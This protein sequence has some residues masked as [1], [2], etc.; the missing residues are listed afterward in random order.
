MAAKRNMD[1]IVQRTPRRQ[2]LQ[3]FIVQ[4]IVSFSKLGKDLHG[5]F[6][7]YSRTAGRLGVPR[8]QN[9]K[10][11][12][13]EEDVFRKNAE[14]QTHRNFISLFRLCIRRNDVGLVG[15]C[16][17][18]GITSG[19]RLREQHIPATQATLCHHQE[20]LPLLFVSTGESRFMGTTVTTC[21]R[22]IITIPGF[23]T[24]CGGDRRCRRS[25]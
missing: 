11:S 4:W 6:K 3:G 13:H 25:V 1:F 16:P 24:R 22:V 10:R 8:I 23:L 14:R 2:P 17:E 7:G 9:M 18:I 19:C 20:Y 5:V 15:T 21:S 12:V